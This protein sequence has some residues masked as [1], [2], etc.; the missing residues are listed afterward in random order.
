MVSFVLENVSVPPEVER[1]VD[2]R[3]SMAAV[4]EQT[5]S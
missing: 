2:Q 1:A 3:S 4:W 5:T